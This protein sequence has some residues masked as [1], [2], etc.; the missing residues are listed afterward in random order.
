MTCTTVL[1]K[2]KTGRHQDDPDALVKVAAESTGWKF[3]TSTAAHARASWRLDGAER[4]TG[5]VRVR[6]SSTC[7]AELPYR[8]ME[9]QDLDFEPAVNVLPQHKEGMPANHLP[10]PLLSISLFSSDPSRPSP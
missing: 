1:V 3:L 6:V 8:W 4:W 9:N 2:S 7:S 5:E 10:P